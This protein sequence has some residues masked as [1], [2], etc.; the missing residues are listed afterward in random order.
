MEDPI[1]LTPDQFEVAVKSLIKKSGFGLSHFSVQRLE[2]LKGSDGEYEIDVTARFRALGADFLVLVECK[3][4]KHSVKRDVVQ[5]L[6]D[7][8]RAVG[9]HKGMIFSTAKFQNGAIKY[10][11]VHGIALVQITDGQA[12][13]AS[14]SDD[15][16]HLLP[17][18]VPEHVGWVIDL[19][20]DDRER[21]RLIYRSDPTTLF[22]MFWAKE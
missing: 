21:Y 6:F 15:T 8:L 5:V 9:A 19:S 3:H 22:P 20:D 10:A 2:K 18:N 1:A 4:Y 17:A 7:R 13:F 11:K 16:S 14:R 12:A